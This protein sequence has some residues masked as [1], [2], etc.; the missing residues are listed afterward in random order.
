[1][2][3]FVELPIETFVNIPN[4]DINLELLDIDIKHFENDIII[5]QSGTGTG[6]T[7]CIAKYA[8]ILKNKYNCRILSVV[9]L[10]SLAREQINT[11]EEVGKIKLNDYQIDMDELIEGDGVICINS[12]PKLSHK[13]NQGKSYD[14]SD[15]I[16]YIDE[17]NDLIQ[18]ITH[19]DN[20]DSILNNVYDT[21]I[22]L[23]KNCKK[24]IVS[25]ATINENVLN[26]LSTR[27]NKNAK[28]VK[29]VNKFQ[30]FKN[31]EA[32]K[33]ND[34]NEFIDELRNHI[35]NK[36]YFLFGSDGCGVITKLYS[37][38]L[39]E[40]PEQIDD[41][42]IYTSKEISN[43]KP[44]SNK[45]KNK[46]VFYSPTIKTGVSFVLKD[47]KQSHFI[48]ITKKPLITPDGIYQMSCRT[49]NIEKL[50]YYTNETKS[51]ELKYN[52]LD[53]LKAKYKNFILCNNKLNGL[54]VNRNIDNDRTVIE[55]S[56]FNCFTYNEYLRNIY[57]TGYI[58]HYENYLIR[59]G[60]V[61]KEKGLKVKIN[62]SE[63]K[64]IKTAFTNYK[65]N[66]FQNFLSCRFDSTVETKLK[67]YEMFNDRL[68]LLKITTR[69]DAEKYSIFIE[70]DYAL[71]NFFNLVNLFKDDDYINTKFEDIGKKSMDVKMINN[72]YSKLKLLKMFETHYKINRFNFDI[73]TVNIDKEISNEFKIMYEE[74]F[75]KQKKQSF[76]TKQNIIQ[77]YV[78]II[79]NI[80]GDIP[81]IKSTKKQ[82]NNVRTYVYE[83]DNEC[84]NN[85]MK[86]AKIGNITLYGFNL[87]LVKS[88]TNII[89][90]EPP[91]H[92]DISEYETLDENERLSKYNF[93]S[94]F[95]NKI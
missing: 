22:D 81:I 79:K 45:F 42:L 86:L 34:E 85:I 23:I 71:K 35:K 83:I 6:K 95:G 50:H 46:Y 56:F 17:I 72:K 91:T 25:D 69:E 44:D 76:T 60:F 31:V 8:P 52:N 82:I 20:L 68:K 94:T 21:L 65:N 4:I 84:A 59:D 57:N 78:K 2:V 30:K 15:V 3:K 93:T 51:N 29:I 62:K 13:D 49:R 55:N 7:R 12:L 18:S 16:L 19:N 70:D 14:M 26:L 74:I 41:F 11:F 87:D 47:L 58:K 80:C 66:L 88:I 53:D 64:E 40:F 9:N 89:P 61:L 10:I 48:Y 36:K 63:D 38:L 77:I 92:F 24:I 67:N 75:S 54:S 39:L 43:G 27:I 90:D 73:N 33:Y 28:V 37:K 5:I 1:M 32:I